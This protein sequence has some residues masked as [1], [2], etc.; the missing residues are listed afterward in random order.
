MLGAI[1]CK[2]P[3]VLRLGFATDNLHRSFP[4]VIQYSFYVRG[5]ISQLFHLNLISFIV[6]WCT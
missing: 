3:Q 1:K 4:H 5:N 6:S 2:Y